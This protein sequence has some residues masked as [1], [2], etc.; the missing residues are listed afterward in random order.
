MLASENTETAVQRKQAGKANSR[1][2]GTFFRHSDLDIA[3]AVLARFVPA[4]V[5]DSLYAQQRIL[6]VSPPFPIEQL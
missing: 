2:A 1:A 5:D 4:F 3:E 6:N